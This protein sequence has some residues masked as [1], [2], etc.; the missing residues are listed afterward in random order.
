[1]F[2]YQGIY[3]GSNN[4][5]RWLARNGITIADAPNV[6]EKFENIKNFINTSIPNVKQFIGFI[7][8]SGTTAPTANILFDSI[9]GLTFSR[10]TGGTYNITKTNAFT[11]N[12]T[13]P[14]EV[15]VVGY[16]VLGNMIVVKQL[17]AHR[18]EIKT[19]TAADTSIL[20]DDILNKLEI[21]LTVYS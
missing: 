16:D 1:M 5:K 8:Q 2:E 13:A 17:S 4:E 14:N 15:G 9:S 21:Q 18:I 10:I 11:L 20:G 12:K 19:Y 3:N 7:S 6:E